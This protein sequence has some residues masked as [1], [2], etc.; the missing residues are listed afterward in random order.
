MLPRGH[1]FL[2][3]VAGLVIYFTFHIPIIY[4][5]LFAASSVLIDFDHYAVAAIKRRKLSL[6]SAF[7]YHRKMLKHEA[8]ENAKGIRVKGDFH[9]F[10]TIEFH[11][12]IL[13]IGLFYAPFLFIFSG[14]LFHSITDLIWLIKDDRLYRREFIFV[15]WLMY[16]RKL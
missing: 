5:V 8:E 7:E 4:S 9:V 13:I 11:L 1:I 12:L 14:M 2:S 6:K 10:H 3:I 15:R 16:S